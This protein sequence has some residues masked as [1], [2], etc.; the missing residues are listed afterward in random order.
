[1]GGSDTTN[2]LGGDDCIVTSS[3]AASEVNA[4][5]GNDSIKGSGAASFYGE[6][7]NDNLRAP[8]MASLVNGGNDIDTCE[9]GYVSNCEIVV[10]PTPT[11]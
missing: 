7:G 1:M 4:G 5:D 10:T 2:G 6:A 11:P 3:N 8:G 9:G